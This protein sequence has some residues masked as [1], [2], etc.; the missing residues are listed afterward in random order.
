M[1][2]KGNGAEA[3]KRHQRRAWAEGDYTSVAGSTVI[4]SELLMEK[5]DI[6]P[7][8]RLLDAACGSGN[9]TLAATRRFADVTGVDF[10][11]ELLRD[12]RVR[13]AAEHLTASLVLGDLEALPFADGSFDAVVSAF[14]VMF[15]P[16]QEHAATEL[17]RVCRPGGRIGLASWTAE[18]ALGELFRVMSRYVPPT[19][20]VPLPTAWGSPERI[21]ELFGASA[22]LVHSR[23]REFVF[24]YHSPE[25]WMHRFK[26]QF[27][28]TKLTFSVL[29]E[30]T[31]TALQR[32][33]LNIWP[34]RN[35]ASDGCLVAPVEYRE[36]ILM[37]DAGFTNPG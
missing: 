1:R 8:Q 3:F 15:A 10:A 13:L 17:V 28:P 12:A 18:G 36:A 5:L 6:R 33:L 29:P 4:A 27:G 20:G 14:G 25:H 37:K 35:R 32:D 19:P 22:R 9:A 31:A 24:R 16:R 23:T 30:E 26:T 21:E 2:R 11:E 34:S 7:A